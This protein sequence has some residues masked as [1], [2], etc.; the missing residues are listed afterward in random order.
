MFK[1]F[2]KI[3]K[4]ALQNQA[5]RQ[6][7]IYAIGEIILVVL[8]ILIARQINNWNEARKQGKIESKILKEIQLD[9]LAT[10]SEIKGDLESHQRALNSSIIFKDFL[11]NSENYQDSI[12]RHFLRSMNDRQTYPKTGGYEALK[13]KGLEIISNDTLRSSITAA[14]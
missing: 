14:Y 5:F 6:Y 3:R 8:G 7:L 11:I 10:Q 2:R 4:K 13:S 9:L 12:L 1:L